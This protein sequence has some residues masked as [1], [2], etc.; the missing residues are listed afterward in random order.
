MLLWVWTLDLAFGGFTLCPAKDF[1][2]YILLAIFNPFHWY[3]FIGEHIG[4]SCCSDSTKFG[5]SIPQPLDFDGHSVKWPL[6]NLL[7]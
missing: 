4:F 6:I 7:L 3:M 2:Y 1:N 5:H